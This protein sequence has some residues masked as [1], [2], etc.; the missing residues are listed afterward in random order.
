MA[1]PLTIRVRL[2]LPPQIAQSRR[3]LPTLG[4]TYLVY[5]VLC[6][7]VASGLSKLGG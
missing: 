6:N 4:V 2:K 5:R 7:P 3:I 1:T